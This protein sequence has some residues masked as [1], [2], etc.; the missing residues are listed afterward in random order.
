M[1]PS[2]P[3]GD[4]HRRSTPVWFSISWRAWEPNVPGKSV[5]FQVHILNLR[6]CT[7]VTGITYHY[8]YFCMTLRVH[9]TCRVTVKASSLHSLMGITKLEEDSSG[10]SKISGHCSAVTPRRDLR[11]SASSPETSDCDDGKQDAQER[12]VQRRRASHIGMVQ[13][14]RTTLQRSSRRIGQP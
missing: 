10:F 5:I 1:N 2:F 13:R 3:A 12:H 8:P 11:H 4:C 6:A 14:M 9:G 7:A